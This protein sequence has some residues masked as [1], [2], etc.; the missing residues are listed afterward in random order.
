MMSR[1]LIMER[2]AIKENNNKKIMDGLEYFKVF[3][4]DNKVPR[5]MSEVFLQVIPLPL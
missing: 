2:K 5:N 1:R 3:I 4:Y